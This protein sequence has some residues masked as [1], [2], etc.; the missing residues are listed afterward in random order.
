M[1]NKDHHRSRLNAARNFPFLS[2][3]VVP[4]WMC[5]NYGRLDVN[6]WCWNGGSGSLFFFII[7][8]QVEDEDDWVMF[9]CW[10]DVRVECGGIGMG[11]C[12]IG[13]EKAG[14]NGG[15]VWPWEFG[16]E[17]SDNWRIW[18]LW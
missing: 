17:V 11:C 14:I 4:C 12:E 10:Y 8:V 18:C 6:V 16:W 15:N 13:M 5:E 3:F 2:V 7:L 1:R 9:V